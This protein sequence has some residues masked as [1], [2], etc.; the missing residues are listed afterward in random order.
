MYN[1]VIP[2][3]VSTCLCVHLSRCHSYL[4]VSTTF[5]H[6][7]FHEESQTDNAGHSCVVNSAIK[8]P[9][10]MSNKPGHLCAM[11]H[12]LQTPPSPSP[13]SLPLLP[14]HFHSMMKSDFQFQ[15]STTVVSTQLY[16]ENLMAVKP[17]LH[18]SKS[19]VVRF[20]NFISPIAIKHSAVK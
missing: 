3:Q 2:A 7:W 10:S 14:G 8:V 18:S 20:K 19:N 15:N 9:P 17:T 16:A 5:T 11:G 4:A 6:E 13:G 1:C 12:V